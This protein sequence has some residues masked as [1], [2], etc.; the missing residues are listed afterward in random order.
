VPHRLLPALAAFMCPPRYLSAVDFVRRDN[1]E[2]YSRLRE[3]LSAS[4]RALVALAAAVGFAV[5]GISG[6]AWAFIPAALAAIFGVVDALLA[7]QGYRAAE[8]SELVGLLSGNAC[9]AARARAVEYGVDVEALPA[10]APWHYVERDFEQQ[11]RAAVAA[12]LSGEGPRLV[13]LSGETKSGKTR[14]AFQLLEWVGLRDAW[15]VVPREGASVE[16][17][18]RAGALP[19]S[20]RPLVVWLDDLEQYASADA[21]GLREGTLRNLECDRP[22]VLLATAG[23][24]GGGSTDRGQ[25]ADPIEQLRALAARIDVPVKLTPGELA[26][27]GRFYGPA[28]MGEI[29][30][31]GLARR[32][33]AIGELR[34][35]LLGSHDDC[36]AGFAVTRAA[37]D[38][39]RAGAQ[40][41]LSVDQLRALYRHYLP[42]DLDPDEELFESGL[43][44]AREPLTSTRISLVRRAAEGGYEPYDLAVEVASHEWPDVTPEALRQIMDL[45]EP[46]DCFQMATAAFDAGDSALAL[47]LLVRAERSEDRRLAATSAFNTGVLLADIGDT[48]AAEIA[49]RRADERGSQRGAFNLGQ[50][51]RHRGELKDAEA[52]YRRADERGSSEGAVNL[53]VLLERRGDLAGAEA[54][55]RRG[56]E[57]GSRKGAGN[58]A[59]L[60]AGRDELTGVEALKPA[61]SNGVESYRSGV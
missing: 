25:L 13:L 56:E 24:R 4:R 27:A 35:K 11:L 53:G 21:G 46:R 15:L 3:V 34:E 16:A 10:G 23:G 44:W 5:Y 28:L 17:L 38:W 55:Y 51:L 33:V 6:G 22:V 2:H 18:L 37:I 29:E 9:R 19:R 12:A 7:W 41:P 20:W 30:Q 45:A 57:R 42:D 60:L 14:A 26:R 39:R 48:A 32:M 36:R 47:D 58:L 61:T 49:Y 59:R 1:P 31:V 8:T 54:A 40:R 43:R 52:A 50:L